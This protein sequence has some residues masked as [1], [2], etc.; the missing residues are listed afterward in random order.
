[1]V[2]LSLSRKT[3]VAVASVTFCVFSM[4]NHANADDSLQKNSLPVI[5]QMRPNHEVVLSESASG[6]NQI[7]F[8]IPVSNASEPVVSYIS[9]E[10]KHVLNRTIDFQ[11]RY[12]SDLDSYF[13]VVM[14]DEQA[15][16]SDYEQLERIDEITQTIRFNG[17]R[18]VVTLEEKDV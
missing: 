5:K 8:S 17:K 2:S 3:S 13:F 14:T 1:M 7:I 15:F 9:R 18:I 11:L 6:S 10:V 16:D 12:E 4:S